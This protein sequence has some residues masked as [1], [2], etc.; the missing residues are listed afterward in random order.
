MR[1]PF[2]LLHAMPPALHAVVL[3]F[4]WDRERLWSLELPVTRVP[5]ADLAWHLRLPLWSFGGRPFVLTPE[6]VAQHPTTF[7]VQYARTTSADLA[8]PIHVLQRPTGLTVLDGMHRLL[9]AR[10]EGHPTVAAKVVPFSRLDDFAQ[11]SP[12]PVSDA[13]GRW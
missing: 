10:L 7:T 9:K 12:D 2:P 6:A 4:L 11:F 1:T 13:P 5:T 8:F 3:D